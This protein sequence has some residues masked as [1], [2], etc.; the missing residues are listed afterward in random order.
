LQGNIKPGITGIF[1]VHLSIHIKHC[2]KNKPALSSVV[3]FSQSAAASDTISNIKA[4][5]GIAKSKLG[6]CTTSEYMYSKL[7]N[8]KTSE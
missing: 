3:T 2:K 8:Q 7:F 4:A 5:L 6:N 1:R